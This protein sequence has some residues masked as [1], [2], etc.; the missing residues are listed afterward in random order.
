MVKPA[1]RLAVAAVF[2]LFGAAGLNLTGGTAAVAAPGAAGTP[3]PVAGVGSAVGRVVDVRTLPAAPAASA[4]TQPV[5]AAPV[6]SGRPLLPSRPTTG[7]KVAPPSLPGTAN[8]GTTAGN[9]AQPN[10]AP[11]VVANFAG[12]SAATCGACLRPSDVNAAVGT[13]QIVEATN[14]RMAVYNKSGTQQCA[15]ITIATLLGSTDS[16]SDPR[17]Q[18]DNVNLRFSFVM[19]VVPA[20]GTATPALW[21][22]ATTG[23]NACGTWNVYRVTFS[24]GSFPAGE[25]LDY[26]ILGQDRNALLFGTDNFGSNR[27]RTVFAIPKSA[28]Y[29]GQGFS[30]SAFNVNAQCA[31]VSNGGIPM[32]SSTFSYFLGSVPG[33]GYQLYRMANSA[34]PNT[35]VTLQATISAPFNAPSR[36]ANQPGTTSTIDPLDGRIAWSPVLASG[37]FIWF[38]HGIDLSG[39][40]AVRYGA[41]NTN[42]NT[43]G[44]MAT[45]FRSATSDDFNPSVGV[46]NNP[47][48]GAFI[49]VNWAYTDAPNNISTSVTVDSVQP[50]AGVPDLHGTG[51]VLVNGSN[52]TDDRFG[53]YSSVAID[54]SNANGSCAVIAQQYFGTDGGW[55]TRIGRVG[56]C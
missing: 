7:R 20:S 17:V 56:T 45:A 43:S 50:G 47:G 18:F 38:A 1:R 55:R 22:A 27:N 24:G 33:T 16:L 5:P 13:T 28:V 14:L 15:T 31:P 49:Y 11:G 23:N 9:Q 52:T 35:S 46:G 2:M 36:R 30:F 41:I 26:P 54:P 19:T 48:G 8:S 12:I 10:V 6:Q 39:F 32:T 21:V 44:G 25:L 4:V 40:P 34:G 51:V 37:G 42:N 29:S 53:D 3:V